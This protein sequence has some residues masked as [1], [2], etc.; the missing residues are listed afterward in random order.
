M[1][2]IVV[3]IFFAVLIWIFINQ[4]KKDT[5]NKLPRSKRVEHTVSYD[6]IEENINNFIKKNHVADD[7]KKKQNKKTNII[8]TDLQDESDY[9]EYIK[10]ILMHKDENKK[11]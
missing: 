7:M 9:E 3:F 4:K 2:I 11:E 8:N 10:E 1:Y 5:K 6:T